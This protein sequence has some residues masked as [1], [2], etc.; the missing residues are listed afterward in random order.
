MLNIPCNITD[1]GY[2]LNKIAIQN[3]ESITCEIVLSMALFVKSSSQQHFCKKNSLISWSFKKQHTFSRWITKAEYHDPATFLS[4]LDGLHMYFHELHV[5]IIRPLTL[6]FNNIGATYLT[7]NVMFRQHT[8]HI[9][10]DLH[11]I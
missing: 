4:S 6:W 11:C 8:K 5:P 1:K 7:V 3:G 10:I 9:E 2:Y